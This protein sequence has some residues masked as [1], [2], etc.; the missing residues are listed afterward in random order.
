[1]VI[2]HFLAAISFPYIGDDSP[3][4]V[5]TP[6]KTSRFIILC[7]GWAV[8]THPGYKLCAVALVHLISNLCHPRA[9]WVKPPDL[10]NSVVSKLRFKGARS[11]RSGCS[12]SGF[13]L[14]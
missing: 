2:G 8:E 1:M 3:G 14:V 12:H 13:F 9:G 4:A 11:Y 6:G 5:E 10:F 7:Y